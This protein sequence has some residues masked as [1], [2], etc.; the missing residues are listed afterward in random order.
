MANYNDLKTSIQ[1][2]IKQNGANQITGN[3]LQQT[4]IS[5]I[6]S[7]GA[8]YTFAGVATPSTNPGTPDQNV[9]YLASE[10]G[11][12]SNFEGVEVKENSIVVF[13]TS[14]GTWNS[15]VLM[16]DAM[17]RS[18]VI[19]AIAEKEKYFF[20]YDNENEL[21]PKV[22]KYLYQNKTIYNN[23]DVVD[24]KIRI[25]SNYFIPIKKDYI[26][27]LNSIKSGYNIELEYFDEKFN[28][29]SAS[30]YQSVPGANFTIYILGT[31]IAYARILFRKSDDSAIDISVINENIAS[32]TCKNSVYADTSDF[33]K[34]LAYDDCNIV[35]ND[36]NDWESKTINNNYEVV[37]NTSRLLSKNK[38]LKIRQFDNNLVI[39]QGVEFQIIVYFFDSAGKVSGLSSSVYNSNTVYDCIIPENTSSYRVLLKH[40]DDTIKYT[41]DKKEELKNLDI[42]IYF[43]SDLLEFSRNISYDMLF[44]DFL[45]RSDA[46]ENNL[47]DNKSISYCN[48]TELSGVFVTEKTRVSSSYIKIDPNTTYALDL[49]KGP[50]SYIFYV[51][52]FDANKKYII[53]TNYFN[54][55]GEFTT[56]GNA[57][58]MAFVC[59]KSISQAVNIYPYEMLYTTPLL[60]KTSRKNSALNLSVDVNTGLT[61][62]KNL[63]MQGSV[64]INEITNYSIRI[65]TVPIRVEKNTQYLIKFSSETLKYYLAFYGTKYGN[66]LTEEFYESPD[67][68]TSDTYYIPKGDGF[69]YIIAASIENP[70]A[71]ITP[72]EIGEGAVSIV[73]TV[74]SFTKLKVSSFNEGG[75]NYGN[76]VDGLPDDGNTASNIEKWKELISKEIVSDIYMAQ[77]HTAIMVRG[78]DEKSYNTLYKQFYPYYVETINGWEAIFS[79]F[80]LANIEKKRTPHNRMYI[81]AEILI[82]STV[83]T[84]VNWHP[85]AGNSES[86]SA[87]RLEENKWLVEKLKGKSH[88]I[89][90]SDTN[91]DYIN[92]SDEINIS[93]LQPFFDDGY[94]SAN[95]G[96]W[97][98]KSTW[99]GA[100]PYPIDTLFVKGLNID[101]FDVLENK[102]TS[103]HYPIV[104]QLT[105]IF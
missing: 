49:S 89:I 15:D 35:P 80:P 47:L 7:L 92:G 86:A 51:S 20:I 54:G 100:K 77:E 1:N 29:V 14:S 69:L 83:V 25:L 75:Y 48:K 74:S 56:S 3:L 50:V 32:I 13:Y 8:N 17:F 62:G 28:F 10:P 87:E 67:Y 22:N 66:D 90:G 81:I 18:G 52:L 71:A 70:N 63:W 45:K 4:L 5:M 42:G 26:Y 72:D 98:S 37:D 11:I 65:R 36:I 38:P 103:D 30:G 34:I 58:Y 46:V 78:Q 84:L 76:T 6:N 57:E 88:V 85:V 39:Y 101:T 27:R 61:L 41:V 12:Y 79:K 16:D 23:G 99:N 104:C 94:I 97:G 21:V 91:I 43:K 31:S 68:L 96:Y 33:Y 59:A 2:V 93:E 24:S 102:A 40:R 19:S 53:T 73:K 9:F 64:L 95:N 82:D 60:Y 44:R 55:Y 105:G